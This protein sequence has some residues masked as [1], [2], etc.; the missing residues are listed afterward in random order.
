MTKKL[1]SSVIAGLFAAAPAYAQDSSDPMRVEG[2]GTL[3]GIYNRTNAF[4]RAQLDLYQDL[5]NGVL[6][7]VG[8][9]GRNRTTW[10]QG[11]GENFGRTDEN[12]CGMS[13]R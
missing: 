1:V 12:V 2:T 6:S 9:Q 7:N 8:V 4:D 3:G 11:Y 5:S 10:F 13:F